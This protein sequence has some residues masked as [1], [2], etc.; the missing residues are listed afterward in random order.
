M[1]I[2]K[3]QILT[4]RIGSMSLGEL[5][6]SFDSSSVIT[7]VIAEDRISKGKVSRIDSKLDGLNETIKEQDHIDNEPVRGDSQKLQTV[8]VSENLE[9]PEVEDVDMALKQK[10]E[11]ER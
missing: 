9:V 1:S 3:Q 2:L 10:T 11:E 5:N 7:S 4:R 6:A 8:R